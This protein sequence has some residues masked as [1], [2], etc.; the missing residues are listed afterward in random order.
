MNLKQL[1]IVAFLFFAT[2]FSIHAG[3]I[4]GKKGIWLQVLGSGGPELNDKRASS[5]YLVWQNGRARVLVDMGP[6]SM[7]RYEESGAN[8]E[9]LEVI[10]LTHLHV[11]HSA[12]LPALI[13]ASYFTERSIDLPIYGPTGN[14]QMPDTISFVHTLFDVPN[15]A[16]RYLAGYLTGNEA[17]RLRANNVSTEGTE[18][19]QVLK[20]NNL[21]ITAV[22][23]HHGPIPAL[24]WRVDIGKYSIAF[25]GD[26]NGDNHTL[27]KLAM[28]AN[29]LVAHHAI[30]Q[31]AT[32]AARELH[33]PPSVIGEIAAEA[34]I[35]KLILSH[36]MK[37]TLGKEVESMAEIR[38]RYTGFMKFA[39][40]GQCFKVD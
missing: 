21:N 11:D 38:K 34:K 25:S 12:D 28:D 15:G 29:M 2:P 3:P 40:D 20:E 19:K 1:A 30:P 9:D 17:F 6:G 24:A 37:R 22:A 32:G 7:L 10:L 31:N 18:I 16:Y 27:P 26:M 5:G 39:N 13:K 4:C 8:F 23:V 36:R 14:S 35:R 33:M